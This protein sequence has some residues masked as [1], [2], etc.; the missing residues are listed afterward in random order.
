M[1]ILQV[2]KNGLLIFVLVVSE[3]CNRGFTSHAHAMTA[4]LEMVDVPSNIAGSY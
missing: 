1:I 4:A 2:I 3:T